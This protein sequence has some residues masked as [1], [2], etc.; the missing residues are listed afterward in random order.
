[1]LTR[2]ENLYVLHFYRIFIGLD[3]TLPLVLRVNYCKKV[4]INVYDKHIL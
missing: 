4:N 1:M 2:A 3:R